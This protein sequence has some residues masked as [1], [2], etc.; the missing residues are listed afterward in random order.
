MCIQG[1]TYRMYE[2]EYIRRTDHIG[3]YKDNEYKQQGPQCAR[4]GR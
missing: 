2:G 3:D 1:L 4:T